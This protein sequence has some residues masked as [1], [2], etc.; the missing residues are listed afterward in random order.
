MTAPLPNRD[1]DGNGGTRWLPET[2]RS[3]YLALLAKRQAKFSDRLLPI[4][5]TGRDGR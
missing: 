1:V 2:A 4:R 5:V 3:A